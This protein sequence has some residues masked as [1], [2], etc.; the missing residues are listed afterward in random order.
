MTLKSGM[1]HQQGPMAEAEIRL[2]LVVSQVERPTEE[3]STEEPSAAD[4]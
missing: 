4:Q 1:E 2:S 3:P